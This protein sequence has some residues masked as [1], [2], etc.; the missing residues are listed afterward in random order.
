MSVSGPYEPPVVSKGAAFA[1]LSSRDRLLTEIEGPVGS[2][3]PASS[4][5]EGRGFFQRLKAV[6]VSD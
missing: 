6:F 3:T 2:A 4:K 5:I 1:A